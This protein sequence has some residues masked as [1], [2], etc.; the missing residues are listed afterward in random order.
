[1][2]HTAVTEANLEALVGA[3]YARVRVH[4][5]SVLSLTRHSPDAGTYIWHVWWIFGRACCLPADALLLQGFLTWSLVRLVLLLVLTVTVGAHDYLV[6]SRM[7]ALAEREGGQATVTVA[8]NRAVLQQVSS[9]ITPISLVTS[10]LL[11]VL[12]LL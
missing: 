4:E 11:A 8:Q 7:Q 9:R 3:F 2:K 5:T 12:T 6:G 10:L 1:M